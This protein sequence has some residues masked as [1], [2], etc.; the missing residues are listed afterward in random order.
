MKHKSLHSRKMPKGKTKGKGFSERGQFL[1]SEPDRYT[2]V[3]DTGFTRR[4][5]DSNWT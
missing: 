2:P 4:G 3:S 5:S 1:G